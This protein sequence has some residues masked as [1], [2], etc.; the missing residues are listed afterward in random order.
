MA[1]NIDCFESIEEIMNKN[2]SDRR[3]AIKLNNQGVKLLNYGL[4]TLSSHFFKK[5]IALDYS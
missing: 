2:I 5:A 3:K 1:S 4:I